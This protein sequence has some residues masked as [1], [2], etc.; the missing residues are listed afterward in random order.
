MR[1]CNK[2]WQMCW[3][4]VQERGLSDLVAMDPDVA[5]ANLMQTDITENPESFDP[6]ISM[7]WH[8]TNQALKYGGPYLLGHDPNG[9]QYCPIC[10]FEKHAE[11]FVAKDEIDDVA[12]QMATWARSVS[13][14]PP[15]N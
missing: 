12:G 11:G 3:T 2:H 13:L 14:I 4:S 1:I 7:H 15:M 8:F 10:E 5:F 9:D 6:M